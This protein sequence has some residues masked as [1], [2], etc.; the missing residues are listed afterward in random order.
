MGA[1]HLTFELEPGPLLAGRAINFLKVLTLGS[2]PI[3]SCPGPVLLFR[4]WTGEGSPAVYV[5]VDT[6]TIR[7]T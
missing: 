7:R 3:R 5:G 2:G 1:M 6:K 4:S